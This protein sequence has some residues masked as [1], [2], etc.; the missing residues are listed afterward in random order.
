MADAGAGGRVGV[1]AGAR[2]AFCRA[3][4]YPPGGARQHALAAKPRQ[5]AF[6]PGDAGT[7]RSAGLSLYQ[8]AEGAPV[9]PA[10]HRALPAVAYGA[11]LRRVGP[12][13]GAESLAGAAGAR[14]G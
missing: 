4:D 5:W 10:P 1:V 8:H 14:R 7:E 2:A 13:A 6:G 3:G 12:G 9:P 11:T